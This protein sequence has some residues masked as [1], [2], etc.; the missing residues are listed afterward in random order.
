MEHDDIVY[1]EEKFPEALVA[2]A[3]LEG[4]GVV[5]GEVAAEGS[6][7]VCEVEGVC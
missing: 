2:A 6:T 1:A 3:L 5:D 4:E 7:R